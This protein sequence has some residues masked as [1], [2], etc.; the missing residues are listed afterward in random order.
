MSPRAK[1]S[2]GKGV[3]DAVDVAACPALEAFAL[4]YLHQ[5]FEVV[6]GSAAAALDAFVEDADLSDVKRLASD[7]RR[8]RDAVGRAPVEQRLRAWQNFGTAWAPRRWADLEK[9][10]SRLHEV[11]DPSGD[12]L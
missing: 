2:G 9:L 6:H 10:F 5:D 3:P 4:G 7:W 1:R 8:F 12:H 11:L